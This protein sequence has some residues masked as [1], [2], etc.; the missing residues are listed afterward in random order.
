M[1]CGKTAQFSDFI[2]ICRTLT[3]MAGLVCEKTVQ[4]LNFIL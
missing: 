2:F 4:F 1:V 3:K